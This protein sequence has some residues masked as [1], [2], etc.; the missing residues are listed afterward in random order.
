[1]FY[2][3]LKPL[4]GIQ[5]NLSGSRCDFLADRKTRMTALAYDLADT[6][7]TS[8]LQQLNRIQRNL[9]GSKIGMSATKFV[10]FEPIGKPTRPPWPLIG[11]EI[12]D[13]F[14]ETSERN[15]T[16]LDRNQYLNVLDPVCVF[17]ADRNTDMATGLWLAETFLTSSL[18]PP[19]RIQRNW[20]GSKISTSCI[21]FVLGLIGKPR[22]LP[23]LWLA[24]TFSN[25]S[26]KLLNGMQRKLTGS[27]TSVSYN[28]VV[29]LRLIGKPR[30][31][32]SIS[33]FETFS[34]SSMQPLNGIE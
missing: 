23:Y 26:L 16:K 6:F 11:W 25:S 20:T 21:K 3:S 31:P 34:T 13:F 15:L 7:S 19:T 12:F 32:P 18:K 9:R 2:F 24:A 10:F 17:R 4:N 22:W 14:S 27:K 28:N 8:S 29:L 5:R 1:M 33:L 30:W